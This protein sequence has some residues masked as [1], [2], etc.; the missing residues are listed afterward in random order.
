MEQPTENDKSATNTKWKKKLSIK[1]KIAALIGSAFLLCA[2]FALVLYFWPS[3]PEC[4]SQ[5]TKDLLQRTAK[6]NQPNKI[7]DGL[8]KGRFLKYVAEDINE[9]NDPGLSD[10]KGLLDTYHTLEGTEFEEPTAQNL[11]LLLRLNPLLQKYKNEWDQSLEFISYSLWGDIITNSIDP[12]TKKIEC[13]AELMVITKFGIWF[14]KPLTYNV[15]V[16]SD[17]RHVMEIYGPN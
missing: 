14:Y 12:Q 13:Q 9:L 7:T 11:F 4:G 2:S 10:F 16:T 6:Q 17:G 15:K 5:K 3:D 1:A 8:P